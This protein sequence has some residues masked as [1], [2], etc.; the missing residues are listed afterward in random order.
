VEG[1]ISIQGNQGTP[2]LAEAQKPYYYCAAE[3]AMEKEFQTTEPAVRTLRAEEIV[4]LL[5]GPRKETFAP[6]M[7]ARGKAC[8]DQAQGW[9]TTRD[10]KGTVQAEADANYYSCV[11][12]VAMTDV[13]DVKNCNVVRKLA[14]G[15]LF[16][17][18]EGP[19]EEKEA[20]ITR[21][22]GKAVKD[23]KEGWV[24]CKGNA[25]TVYA[26]PSKKHWSIVQEQPLT[27]LFKSTGAV[28]EVRRL[29][30]GEAVL[31]LEG[32]KEETFPAE[33]RI[34]GRA[35]SDGAIGWITLKGT[36]VKKWSPYYKVVVA[37]PAHDTKAAEGAQVLRETNVGEVVEWLEGPVE[38]GK[39]LRMKA[40]LQK[41]GV[42]GW[43]SIRDAEGKR[44]MDNAA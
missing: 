16:T 37:G 9:F 24:T 40:R 2:F 30:A 11:T 19:V 18:T 42:V 6:A 15:E 7:R 22:K 12:S 43:V 1:W 35:L 41:D 25:G 44:L 23:D 17:V 29:E 39:E 28:E 5:E 10:K 27:K 20:G 26:E 3:N 8:K 14:V 4:E 21:V 34:K 13:L 33:T 31:L 38:E 36:T 32:P